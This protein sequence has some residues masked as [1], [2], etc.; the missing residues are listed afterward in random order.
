MNNKTCLK[1]PTKKHVWSFLEQCN[2]YLSKTEYIATC[3]YRCINC[4]K[5]KDVQTKHTNGDIANSEMTEDEHNFMNFCK[6]Q[7]L[8]KFSPVS[9]FIKANNNNKAAT[10]FWLLMVYMD[11]NRKYL[12]ENI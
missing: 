1:S 8:E 12:K 6:E 7:S 4:K 5:I 3:T 10:F 2:A 9:Y 11:Y